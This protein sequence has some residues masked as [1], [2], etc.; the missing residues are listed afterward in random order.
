MRKENCAWALGTP[1]TTALLLYA[2]FLALADTPVSE[3]MNL[4]YTAKMPKLL[5]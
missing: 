2:A 4:D 5:E 3:I 1:P